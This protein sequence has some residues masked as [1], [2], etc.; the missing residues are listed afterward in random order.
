MSDYRKPTEIWLKRLPKNEGKKVGENCNLKVELFP[1]F[2][3]SK[4][5]EPGSDLFSPRLP[6]QGEARKE[7]WSKRYRIR[8]N[9]KWEGS[10][11]KYVTYTK[12]MIRERYFG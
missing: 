9:G 8:V 7:Y 1:A 5:W 11:A 2:Y 6:L 10:R 4:H 12:A 3:W